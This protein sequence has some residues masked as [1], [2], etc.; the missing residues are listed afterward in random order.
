MGATDATLLL[1]LLLLLLRQQLPLLLFQQPLLLGSTRCKPA[2]IAD[3]TPQQRYPNG[4]P[5]RG[6]GHFFM[7]VYFSLPPPP[8]VSTAAC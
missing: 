1:L 8:P 2:Y 4:P 5:L 3:K 7:V 6:P